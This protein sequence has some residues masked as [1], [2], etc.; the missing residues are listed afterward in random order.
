MKYKIV[1]KYPT[2]HY[3]DFQSDT[4]DLDTI[5]NI[6]AHDKCV[7]IG[8]ALYTFDNIITIEQI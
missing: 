4:K 5:Q 3:N 1:V 2:T 6:L 8:N 7:I